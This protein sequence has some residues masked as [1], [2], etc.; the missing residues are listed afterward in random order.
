[1]I[2]GSYLNVACIPS[3]ALIRSAEV[4]ALAARAGEFGTV[5]PSAAR[6]MARIAARTAEIV[7]S[8][9]QANGRA[10]DASGCLCRSGDGSSLPAAR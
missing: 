4:A 7:D 10:F 6:D 9:V 8:M 3:K 1:M 5:L 2:G